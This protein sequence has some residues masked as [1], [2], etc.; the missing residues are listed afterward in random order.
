MRVSIVIPAYNEAGRIGRTL[1][2]YG[3]FFTDKKIQTGLDFELLV[4][5]NGCKDN[6]L[7]VVQNAQKE[8][9]EIRIIDLKEAGKGLAII[10]G[11][12]DAL[13]RPHDLIGFVDADMATAPQYFYDLITNIDGYDGIIASRYMKGSDIEPK[14]P[15]VKE[16]GRKLI[17]HPLIRLLFG[18]WHSDYQCGAKLFKGYVIENIVHEL[19]VGQWAFDVDLLYLCK[20]HGYKIHEIP[21][22]WHDQDDSKLKILGGGTR[23]ISSLFKLRLHHSRF[24]GLLTQEN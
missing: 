3:A 20:K 9:P 24:K 19:S 7:E 18:M 13:K 14:R 6:T 17:F 23:I 10:H 8:Y 1:R 12:K 2:T 21:T 5:L 22:I 16:W 4:V 11:F 15:F